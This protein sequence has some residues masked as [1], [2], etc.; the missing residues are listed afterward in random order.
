MTEEGKQLLIDQLASPQVKV[1]RDSAHFSSGSPDH[2]QLLQQHDPGQDDGG[3]D[4]R[5]HDVQG[6]RNAAD[7]GLRDHAHQ[8]R[9]KKFTKYNMSLLCIAV[10]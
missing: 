7:R 6:H 8:Q 5:P 2:D 3:V 1:K 4:G 9:G 10:C